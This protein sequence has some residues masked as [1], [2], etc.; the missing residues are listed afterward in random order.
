MSHVAISMCP[1]EAQNHVRDVYIIQVVTIC[2]TVTPSRAPAVHRNG[3]VWT[4]SLDCRLEVQSQIPTYLPQPLGVPRTLPGS[5]ML[6]FNTLP[7]LWHR[8]CCGSH[9]G[10]GLSRSHTEIPQHSSRVGG[11]VFIAVSQAQGGTENNA[12]GLLTTREASKAKRC[13]CLPG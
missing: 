11:L 5:L 7:Y 6:I 3:P 9:P 2:H 1:D 12:P 13:F 8:G 4:P 10:D